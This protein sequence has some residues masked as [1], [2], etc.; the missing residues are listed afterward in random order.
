MPKGCLLWC[1]CS[2]S[3]YKIFETD[4]M[5]SSIAI[6]C[7]TEPVILGQ[8]LTTWTL[9]SFCVCHNRQTFGK[10][11]TST[12]WSCEPV[13][14]LLS[15]KRYGIYIWTSIDPWGTPVNKVK[16][17]RGLGWDDGCLMPTM[18]NNTKWNQ[19]IA[20]QTKRHF[21]QRAIHLLFPVYNHNRLDQRQSYGVPL[22]HWGPTK[23]STYIYIRYTPCIQQEKKF[24]LQ[25]E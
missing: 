14:C 19:Q 2:T 25:I 13:D 15:E 17:L 7:W 6:I 23:G 10:N 18:K 9:F 4:K 24:I 1:I 11:S 12:S 20:D 21:T 5:L 3:K 8:I 22:F 16:G